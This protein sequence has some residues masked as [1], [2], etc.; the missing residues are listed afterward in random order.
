MGVLIR[1]FGSQL[2][3][4]GFI[5]GITAMISGGGLL[6]WHNHNTALVNKGIQQATT[7][8]RAKANAETVRNAKINAAIVVGD[9]QDAAKIR[10]ANERLKECVK[11]ALAAN[12]AGDYRGAVKLLN[13]CIK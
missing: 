1:V 7:K 5:A 8:I 13:D 6:W 9:T 10:I 11:R 3:A 2:A 12:D 4:W